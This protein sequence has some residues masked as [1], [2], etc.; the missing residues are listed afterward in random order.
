M[1]AEEISQREF[2]TALRGYDRDEVDA[3]LREVA[4]EVR[5]LRKQIASA[6]ADAPPPPPSPTEPET[7]AASDP[8]EAY[9]R[10]G[11]ETSKILI[12]AEQVAN[13][14]KEK[15]RRE[16]AEVLADARQLAD[17]TKRESKEQQ[18]AA[19]AEI[20]KLLGTRSMLATQLEDVRRRL[21]ETIARLQA[22]V[23]LPAAMPPKTAP[24][25]T[26]PST[27]PPPTAATPP[28]PAAP[29]AK[30]Q[31]PAP[32]SQPP[33]PSIP[34][35]EPTQPST[36]TE[37]K[38]T[39]A[40][41][42]ASA[43]TA[44]AST[45]KERPAPAPLSQSPVAPP[46]PKAATKTDAVQPLQETAGKAPTEAAPRQTDLGELLAEIR[47]ER[48]AGA[49]Q[50][51]QVLSSLAPSTQPESKPASSAPLAPKAMAA[52]PLEARS[53]ALGEDPLNASRR[54][55]R[56]LQED[57]N[58]LLDKLRTKRGK[59]TAEENMVS[60]EHHTA[61]FL[62]GLTEL[63][64]RAFTQGRKVGGSEEPGDPSTAVSNLV[65]RQLVTPLRAEL[66]KVLEE[67][68]TAQD[69]A[70]SISERASDVY[71]VWKGVRTE[72]LGEGMVY[73]AFHQGL[74]DAWNVKGAAQKTWVLSTDEV[75]C[76]K[77]ICKKNSEAGGVAIGGAFPS[78]HLAPPAHGGCTC[79]LQGP[80]S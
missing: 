36:T 67:G 4:D 42:S 38:K 31:A 32:V 47:E 76:P 27:P 34:K 80:E 28:P 40:P 41:A 6:G 35:A 9:K 14:I 56:L 71:R 54:M 33:A 53:A 78:G 29:P 2:L 18:E 70:T 3:Y 61:R 79:T 65:A 8:S 69:T 57:Q 59:G 50:V 15:A 62:D 17:K 20:K 74:M 16:A 23:D 43:P 37:A 11:E 24:A 26:R 44:S 13:E 64:E 55:K 25:P 75:E 39:T 19:D 7:V 58:E 1:E 5:S 60:V 10:V 66:S 73:A 48:Q 46:P 72:L 51:D 77:D 52:G 22:P 45:V 49:R 21:D 30:Q 12:S 63:L 68:L